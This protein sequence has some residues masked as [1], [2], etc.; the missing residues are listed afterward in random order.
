MLYC[1]SQIMNG[2]NTNESRSRTGLWERTPSEF[3]CQIGLNGRS[4]T[5]TS[6]RETYLEGVTEKRDPLF[7]IVRPEWN[8]WI[9]LTANPSTRGDQKRERVTIF[10]DDSPGERHTGLIM[11]VMTR[12][13]R[14]LGC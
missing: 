10:R 8:R 11:P 5:L 6:G 1:T 7:A 9:T 4:A 2:G 13:R 3:A 14:S 12:C